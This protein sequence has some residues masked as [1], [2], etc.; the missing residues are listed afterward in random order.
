MAHESVAEY[1]LEMQSEERETIRN[2]W[3]PTLR[4]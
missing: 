4:A 1:H 2:G 3:Q